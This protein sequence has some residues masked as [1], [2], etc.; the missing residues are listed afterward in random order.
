MFK[1]LAVLA[2]IAFVLALVFPLPTS[3]VTYKTEYPIACSALWPAVKDTLSNKTNYQIKKI[4]DSKMT[5]SYKVNHAIHI[6]ITELF[7]QT[8]NKVTLVTQGTGCEMQDASNYS[9]IEHDDEGDFKTRVNASLVKFG[10]KAAAD[11]AKPSDAAQP[12]A[13]PK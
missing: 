9:G 8:V 2:A 11:A 1:K 13:P 10:Q 6:T 3:A 4:D 12:A 5:A 7:T